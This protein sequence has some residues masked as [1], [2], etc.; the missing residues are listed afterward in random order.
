MTEKEIRILLGQYA[1]AELSLLEM[2][3][4]ADEEPVS[5]KY[6]KRM[7][8]LFKTEKYFGTHIDLGSFVRKAA[9]F[10]IC[11]MFLFGAGEVSAH[12]FG[13]DPWEYVLSVISDIKMER[14]Q[15]TKEDKEI[16]ANTFYEPMREIPEYIPEGL[17]QNS[18]EKPYD[19]DI[20]ADWF[21]EDQ[22]KAV[23]YSRYT[24]H[25]GTVISSDAEYLK[26]EKCRVGGYVAYYYQKEDEN[27]ISWEDKK[28][29]Y[30]IYLT[31]IKSPK[32][33]LLKMA[34]SIYEQ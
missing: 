8:K 23:Q 26:K 6:K 9:I 2:P 5:L 34:E 30:Q 1:E 24:I 15:Y 28:Y 21:S 25:E 17:V 16:D 4:I 18:V 22:K 7:K 20:Y 10:L 32:E 29:A 31:G 33:E 3:D 27:W 19:D 11:L 14:R 12:V 13:V